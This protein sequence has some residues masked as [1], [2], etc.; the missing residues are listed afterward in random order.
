MTKSI[1]LALL[2][3]FVIKLCNQVRYPVM[4][5]IKNEHIPS[6]SRA[7]T[8][9][10]LSMIDSF[11]DVLVFASLGVISNL[12]LSYVFLGSAVVVFVGLLFPVRLKS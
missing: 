7:T 1:F 10:L 6:G 9:S 5:Q 2:V 4:S 11:F 12:G 3:F 8:L